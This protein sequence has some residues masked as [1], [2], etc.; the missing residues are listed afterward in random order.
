MRLPLSLFLVVIAFA[1]CPCGAPPPPPPDSS[2]GRVAAVA[3]DGGFEI[4][5]SDLER[6]VRSLQ[7]DVKLEGAQA[8]AAEAAGGS[9]IVEA[10]LAA[11]KDDFTVVVGD[12]RRLN[13]PGGAVVK[14]TTDA[15]PSSIT[16][17]RALAVDDEGARRTVTVVVP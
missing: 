14:V 5:L 4:R 15:A 3:V 16:L 9:D 8:T 2:V 7:V 6:P 1:G 10:G 13:L 12:T 11:P 17:S